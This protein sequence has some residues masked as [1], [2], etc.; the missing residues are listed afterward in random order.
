MR[1]ERDNKNIKITSSR[2][3]M[4]VLGLIAVAAVFAAASVAFAGE[5][6]YEG[7]ADGFAFAPGSSSSPTDLFSN[8]NDVVPGDELTD[9]VDVKNNGDKT[10]R[11]YM[12]ALGDVDGDAAFLSQMNLKVEKSG[13]TLFDAP[14]DQTA[15]LTDWVLL[16]TMAPGAKAT[17]DLTLSVP[18]TMGNDSQDAVGKIGWQFKAE[19]VTDGPVNPD[20]PDDLDK[21]KDGGRS[22]RTGDV[23]PVGIIIAIMIAA[24]AAAII[25]LLRRRSRRV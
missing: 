15:G 10:V 5:V 16:G 18:I 17:L 9:S 4:L 14:A 21:D 6:S 12:R 11:L 2:G 7:E 19:E 13:G 25:V 8:F 1:H 22:T 20:D 3:R 24:A 23:S